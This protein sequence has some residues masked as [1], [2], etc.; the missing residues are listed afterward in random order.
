M[1]GYVEIARRT[2]RYIDSD[3]LLIKES[4][5]PENLRIL[6][7]SLSKENC[8]HS[9]R[10][11]GPNGT[12]DDLLKWENERR[13]TEIFFFYLRRGGQLQTVGAGAVAY[14]LNKDFPHPGFCVLGRC[15]IMPEY[16][17]NGYYRQVLRYR[18]DHCRTKFGRGLNAIHIGAVN[19]RISKVIVDHGIPGWPNFTHI[20][21]EDLK[22]ADSVMRVGAYLLFMPD[23]VYRMLQ[24]LD[25]AD[26]P[27]C[28][29]ELRHALAG[30]E[31]P[32][33]R[34]LGLTVKAKYEE[35]KACGWFEK[36][37]A[38]EIEQFLEFCRSVPLVGFH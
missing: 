15:I 29:I 8:A 33:V 28:V 10:N 2:P 27:G 32:D 26:A 6:L 21:E 35:A 14:K 22:V 11:F 23:Y 30:L 31:S 20:G 4:V 13:P 38:F 37:D 19:E 25:G 16:R 17:S 9:W 12:L 1:T 7:D 18:L 34:N 5:S 36:R 3:E 24:T